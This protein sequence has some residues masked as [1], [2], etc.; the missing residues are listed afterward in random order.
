MQSLA[1]YLYRA[2]LRGELHFL[3][4]GGRGLEAHGYVRNTK[5]VDFLTAVED[6]PA[7]ERLLQAAGYHKEAE[8]EHF[9]R[10]RHHSLAAED[11]DVMLVSATTF[12]A[13]ASDA[14]TMQLGSAALRIPSAKGL[15]ALKFH[16]MKN[17]P[18]RFA[19]DIADVLALARCAPE[20][21][22]AEE[23]RALCGR[24]GTPALRDKLEIL[25]Q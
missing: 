20:E 6:A 21:L 8:T 12:A 14:V 17:N 19:K 25:L 7:M 9:S 13:L 18:D 1:E 24:Y 2:E 22:P 5:D 23:L 16:A 3:L 4:I 11:V 15:V 10:W